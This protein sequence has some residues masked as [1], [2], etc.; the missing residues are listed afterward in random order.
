MADPKHI[1]QILHGTYRIKRLIGKG[2]MGAVYE[3]SHLRL[4]RRFAV[5][6][7]FADAS[8]D[9]DAVARFQREAQ[10]TSDLGHPNIVE[11]VDFHHTDEGEPYIVMEMLKGEDL[12]KRLRK[13]K[14]FTLDEATAVLE[15][16]A[17]A[18]QAAHDEGIIHRDLKPQNIFLCDTKK[19]KDLVKVVD[20]GIAKIL[21]SKNSMAQTKGIIGT[22]WY[23]SPE[24]VK[25][26]T[27]R[28]D[29]R[30]DIF[31]MGAIMFELLT[32]EPPF[33]GEAPAVMY[34]IVHKDLPS[35]RALRPDVPEE[36]E[37]AIARALAKEPEDRYATIEEFAHDVSL[38]EEY[39]GPI[40]EVDTS[41]HGLTPPPEDAGEPTVLDG[42]ILEGPATPPPTPGV[43]GEAATREAITEEREVPT[44]PVPR[45]QEQQKRTT[46][47][48]GMGEVLAPAGG[49]RGKVMALAA[50]VVVVLALAAGGIILG[51]GEDNPTGVAAKAPPPVKKEPAAVPREE[52]AP[53]PAKKPAPAARLDS[54]VMVVV[55]PGP[56]AKPKAPAKAPPAETTPAPAPKAKVEPKPK[57]PPPRPRPRRRTFGAVRVGTMSGGELVRADIFLD[58]KPRGESPTVL[59][60]VPAG[61]HVITAKNSGFRTVK[62]AVTVRPGKVERVMLDLV[63]AP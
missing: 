14:R 55:I 9:R 32:G 51:L 13:I 27:E 21:G 56:V 10:V 45:P 24:R 37:R 42:S 26:E 48:T 49:G 46:H 35:L 52:P 54:G 28:V 6:L 62:R 12:G 34:Q 39:R 30:A 50:G 19:Q 18:L 2:G 58:G 40:L 29:H 25:N 44:A 53:T 8:A 5:K 23:M 1:G 15:Q 16:A 41:P 36:V 43:T 38:P 47:T 63:P 3:A 60:R 57:A 11:V 4:P 59:Q 61:R 31:S 20:F 33:T 22:A 7:L 17:S